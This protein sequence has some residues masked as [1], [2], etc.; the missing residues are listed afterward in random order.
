MAYTSNKKIDG[1]TEATSL[2]DS[3]ALPVSQS[4]NT[5]RVALSVLRDYIFG[6]RTGLTPEVGDA[7]V[8][9]VRQPDNVLRQV[10]LP[11]LVPLGGIGNAKIAADAAI[12]HS[13]LAAL[14]PGRVIVGSSDSVPTA[15]Q[16]GGDASLSPSGGLTIG[17][18]AVTAA[19]LATASVT[20]P[21]MNQDG[22]APVFGCRA[23]CRFNGT[24]VSGLD[25]RC[26]ITSSGNIDRVTRVGLGLFHV[27]FNTAMP[28]NSYTAVVTAYHSVLDSYGVSCSV[29]MINNS[30]FS[31]SVGRIFGSV[32]ARYNPTSVDV[33]V[34]C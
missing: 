20:A 14:S 31:I 16:I 15:V 12:A 21:K 3:H 28:Y 13:K 25:N 5:L 32:N 22:T 34:F 4:G 8:V 10:S 2:A 29:D 19:K 1:L 18:G 6:A 27:F 33:C 30:S 7:S 24:S 17:N 23:F 9:I 26:L 11:D